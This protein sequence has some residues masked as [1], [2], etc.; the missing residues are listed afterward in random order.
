MRGARQCLLVW[1]RLSHQRGRC[2][3]SSMGVAL[4]VCAFV[5]A[6]FL[7]MAGETTLADAVTRSEGRSA[8]IAVDISSLTPASL[9]DLHTLRTSIERLSHEPA[10]IVYA[11]ENVDCAGTPP[12][13]SVV[14]VDGPLSTFGGPLSA[15][16]VQSLSAQGLVYESPAVEESSHE[17]CTPLRHRARIVGTVPQNA[18]ADLLGIKKDGLILITSS[19]VSGLELS[20][21]SAKIAVVVPE[22][23]AVR[24]RTALGS[25][26]RVWL[27]TLSLPTP[28][29]IEVRRI[30]TTAQFAAT[31]DA[32]STIL[33]VVGVLGLTAGVSGVVSAQL[34]ALP[35]RL[36]FFALCRAVGGSQTDIFRLSFVEGATIVALGVLAG[37]GIIAICLAGFG[38]DLVRALGT[39]TAIPH[40]SAPFVQ[41]IAACAPAAVIA[42]CIPA[43]RARNDV[44]RASRDL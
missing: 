13:P 7:G 1:R 6:R 5:L 36:R 21:S 32:L 41:A 19:A 40:T 29:T 14:L 39:S 15:P 28:P 10:T 2:V 44:L 18:S 3:A 43:W 25:T 37:C 12:G 9:A 27:S 20:A 23:D 34:A 35:I 24:V 42:G 31:Q 30:D 4:A 38:D 11:V 22:S 16:S 17:W 8:T 33:T 26:S